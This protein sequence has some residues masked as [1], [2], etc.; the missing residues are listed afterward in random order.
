MSWK[1]L[2]EIVEALNKSWSEELG[3]P[4]KIILSNE[5]IEITE[6]EVILKVPVVF[7]IRLAADQLDTD[8]IAECIS[9][10]SQSRSQ[11]RTPSGPKT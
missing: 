9:R 11:S 2:C 4:G 3:Q 1:K 5:H 8:D 10:S 7:T 6:K